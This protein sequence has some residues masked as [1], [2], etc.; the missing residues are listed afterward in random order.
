MPTLPASSPVGYLGVIT[1]AFG[2]FL[3]LAGLDIINWEKINVAHGPKTWGFG[4]FLALLGIVFLL[5]DL[6]G[7][8]SQLPIPAP[9]AVVAI[10]TPTP[11]TEIAVTEESPT[12]TPEPKPPTDTPTLQPSNTSTPKPSDT[13][14]PPTAT[15]SPAPTD[16]STPTVTRL[17]TPTRTLTPT[18]TPIPMPNIPIY[19]DFADGILDHNKWGPPSWGNPQQYTPSESQ[20]ELRFEIADKWIDWMIPDT[21]SVREFDT[22][23][24]IDQATTGAMGFTI[25]SH[26]IRYGL[27]IR[28]DN[29][30]MIT[31]EAFNLLEGIKLPGRCCPSTHLLGAKADGQQMHL[32]VDGNLTSSYPFSGY[33]NLVGL[34]IIADGPTIAHVSDVWVDFSQ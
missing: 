19:D 13:P 18:P 9:T 27:Y 30:I 31:G 21:R 20:G 6:L 12:K 5:P 25:G 2:I 32:Y 24:T 17:P 15:L 7:T 26:Q 22:L 11:Q 8:F 29:K 28:G 10:S 34:Q 14:K 4:I 33:P 3:I 23:V 16:T 1:L